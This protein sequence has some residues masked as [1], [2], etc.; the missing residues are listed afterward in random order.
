MQVLVR[1]TDLRRCIVTFKENRIGIDDWDFHVFILRENHS[2][3]RGLTEWI[4]F[5]DI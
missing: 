1:F 2:H 4:F 5:R 3:L